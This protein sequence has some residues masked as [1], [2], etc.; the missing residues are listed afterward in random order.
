MRKS[1][2]LVIIA[3]C[4]LVG[5]GFLIPLWPL[6]ALGILLA[7][8]SGRYFVAIALGLLLD[9]AYGAPV[10]SMHFMYAPFTLLALCIDAMHF[11]LGGY[12]REKRRDTL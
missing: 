8:A 10:G 1:L 9:V 12:F 11:Y 2:T 3:S 4:L 6:A 5:A 7:A